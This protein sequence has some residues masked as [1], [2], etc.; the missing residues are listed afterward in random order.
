VSAREQSTGI[1][2]YFQGI[3]LSFRF[4]FRAPWRH[5]SDEKSIAL[6]LVLSNSRA[7]AI[8]VWTNFSKS[9]ITAA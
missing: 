9:D 8:A 6:R 2:N 5:A 4:E 1:Q 7:E 3:G